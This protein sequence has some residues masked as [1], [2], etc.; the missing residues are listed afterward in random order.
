MTP[1]VC[2]STIVISI[3]A[4]ISLVLLSPV[5]AQ[6]P[7][8]NAN[9]QTLTAYGN[10]EVRVPPD[11]LVVDLGVETQAPTTSQASRENAPKAR[12]IVDAMTALGIPMESI[13]TSVYSIQPIQRYPSPSANSQLPPPIVGYQ[14][15]NMIA[16]TTN[17]LSLASRIIDDGVK[18]GANRV[19]NVVFT[20]KNDTSYRQN[21]LAQA[22]GNARASAQA[23]ASALGVELVRVQTVE[24]GGS[25]VVQPFARNIAF[26]AQAAPTPVLPGELSIQASVTIIYAIK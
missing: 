12:A 23:M 20:V 8:V 24:Q 2:T 5:Y 22:I 6:A 4:V 14:V 11:K 7:S 26:A 17:D 13:N 18:A 1:R 9:L 15:V 16:V 21:A 25:P 10:A 19:D 3:F